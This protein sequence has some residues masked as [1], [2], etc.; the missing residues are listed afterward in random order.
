MKK[1]LN[2]KVLV[3]GDILLTTTGALVSKGI[4]KGT[5]SD[6]SH[7]MLYVTHSSIIHAD[8][9]GVHAENTQRIL[10][11]G[12]DAVHALRLKGGLP[13]GKALAICDRV[14]GTVG[15]E[16]SIIEA[17]KAASERWKEASSKQFCSRLVAQAYRAEGYLLV[18][19]PDYCAP[20]AF[21][22]SD[23]LDPVDNATVDVSDE[24][25]E[26]IASIPN[27]PDLMRSTTNAVLRGVRKF[28]RQVQTWSDI[29]K[30]VSENPQH[31]LAV[32]DTIV[33]SGFLDLWDDDLKRY[34][35]RYDAVLMNGM[36][37]NDGLREYCRATMLAEP[38]D[39]NRFTKSLA[40]LKLNHAVYP[41]AT[42][43]VLIDLYERL[44]ELHRLRI[45]AASQWLSR[46]DGSTS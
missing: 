20:G 33:S 2:E 32:R 41:R 15:T 18:P 45:D 42:F 27:T 25:A 31:D 29:G 38:R 19:N 46:N 36:P 5:R 11:E 10:F 21:L 44:S 39:D 34:P 9:H 8:T 4:R 1:R 16:Y 24:E 12:N 30:F 37:S 23:I 35:W 13:Q 43:A 22:K 3:P 14:R 7:V 6:V 40:G 17:M 26:A 28:D